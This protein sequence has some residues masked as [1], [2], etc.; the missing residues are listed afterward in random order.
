MSRERR[1]NNMQ[2][3]VLK[4]WTGINEIEGQ[5]TINGENQRNQ[6]SYIKKINKVYKLFE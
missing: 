2:K 4:I 5:T 6:R 3:E 1:G